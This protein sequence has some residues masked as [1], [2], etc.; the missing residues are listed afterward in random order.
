[1]TLRLDLE[2]EETRR[3]VCTPEEQREFATLGRQLLANDVSLEEIQAAL[4]YEELEGVQ[5]ALDF[6][7]VTTARLEQL[8]A[9]ARQRLGTQAGEPARGKPSGPRVWTP[10]ARLAGARSPAPA[11]SADKERR[12]AGAAAAKPEKREYLTRAQHRRFRDHIDRLRAVD[13]RFRSWPLLARAAGVSSGQIAQRAYEV[14]TSVAT[15]R[16]LETFSRLHAAFGSRATLALMEGIAVAELQNHLMTKAEADAEAGGEENASM[17]EDTETPGAAEARGTAETPGAAEA[18]GAADDGAGKDPEPGRFG[19][20]AAG[21]PRRRRRKNVHLNEAQHRKLRETVEAMW[22]RD[23]KLRNWTLLAKAAGL[24]TGPAVKRAYEVNS[25]TTTLDNLSRF[26]SVHAAHG[27][28]AIAA[29][30]SGVGTEAL[31]EHLEGAGGRGGEPPAASQELHPAATAPSSPAEPGPEPQRDTLPRVDFARLVELGESI[32]SEVRQLWHASRLFDEVA[33]QP[34][35]PR[36][37]RTNAAIARDR[38]RGV[39]DLFAGEGGP[40]E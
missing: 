38:L 36:M 40:G 20:R 26:A 24:S 15:L 7:R 21:G 17:T 12:E 9:L 23:P 35:V 4:G 22:E 16:N 5:R 1:M 11:T 14:G 33:N 2:S 27:A 30:K 37:I 28:A 32:D 3:R 29:L 10:P 25:S 39:I 13:T 8:R 31:E 6:A 34:S 19:R 18:P